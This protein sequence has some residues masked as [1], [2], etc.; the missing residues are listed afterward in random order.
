MNGH[1]W[2]VANYEQLMHGSLRSVFSYD[3][4]LIK[5]DLAEDAAGRSKV[6]SEASDIWCD[7]Y[8]TPG[9]IAG[10]FDHKG[11][12]HMFNN[13]GKEVDTRYLRKNMIFR[14]SLL[15]NNCSKIEVP[16]C[17]KRLDCVTTMSYCKIDE[18][19]IPASVKSLSTGVFR[20]CSFKKVCLPPSLTR[21]PSYAFHKCECLE[22][23]EIPASVEVIECGAFL[24]CK[25][26]KRV[27]IA[28][29]TQVFAG[30]T[31]VLSKNETSLFPSAFDRCAS[32]TYDGIEVYNANEATSKALKHQILKAQYRES[33]IQQRTT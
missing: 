8:F 23:V 21:I 25:A 22:E 14:S 9:M 17:F 7:D 19:V 4:L 29:S 24:S 15:V 13:M 20:C 11:K 3:E 32:L 30:S 28:G 27:K 10:V 12:L 26:L 16:D 2:I 5:L 1:E 18:I 6:L 31:E 33:S